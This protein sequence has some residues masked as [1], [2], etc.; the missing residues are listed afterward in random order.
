MICPPLFTTLDD[1]ED[2]FAANLSSMSAKKPN[3]LTP[4]FISKIWCIDE[5]KAASALQQN[6]HLNRR[7]NDTSLSRHYSTNDRMLRYK[8]NNSLFYTDTFFVTGDGKSRPRGNTCMQI[9]VSDKGFVDVYPMKRK[10]QFKDVLRLFCKEIGV[11]DKLVVD[12]SGEQTSSSVKNFCNQVCLTLRILEESTQWANRAELYIGL[13]KEAIRKDLRTSNCP[14]VLWDYCAER[15]ALIHNLVPQKM[16][17][18]SGQTPMTAT[19]GIQ[20]D[21]SNLCNFSWYDWCYY[22]EEGKHQFPFQKYLLGRVLGPTKNEGDSMAQNVLTHR[23]TIVP[24]RTLRRLTQ[25]ELANAVE[26]KK[27][28]D[29]DKIILNLLGDSLNLPKTDNL[30]LDLDLQDFSDVPDL[31]ADSFSSPHQ[32]GR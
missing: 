21:I 10:G 13:L 22:R 25:D 31:D 14:L 23:G 17:Q 15:R 9:F 32:M 16:F 20:G 12:P 11:P 26:T 3:T 27:R 6:T 30:P 7:S 8:R 5:D 19:L 28:D 29:F 1:L 24:R 4:D 18:N 2:K